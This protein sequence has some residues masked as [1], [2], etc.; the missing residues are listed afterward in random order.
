MATVTRPVCGARDAS[1]PPSGD[2]GWQL[3]AARA[4][5]SGGFRGDLADAVGRQKRQYGLP[6]P[7][8]VAERIILGE[9]ML[10]PGLVHAGRRA[11]EERTGG[12]AMLHHKA[13]GS[14]ID[15]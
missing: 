7:V 5:A 13:D 14:G 11:V 9:E 15:I 8:V 10:G 3:P 1:L 4:I 12:L 2:D 6:R